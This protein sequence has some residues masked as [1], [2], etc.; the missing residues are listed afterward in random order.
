M[1]RMEL[2]YLE[3]V[4]FRHLHW[5]EITELISIHWA[6]SHF[7]EEQLLA[8][9][10]LREIKGLDSPARVF[11]K[12]SAVVREAIKA[13]VHVQLTGEQIGI[14]SALGG[15]QEFHDLRLRIRNALVRNEESKNVRP[16]I[17]CASTSGGSVN[18]VSHLE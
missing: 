13:A 11:R 15:L 6:H 2:L 18:V 14:E 5:D 3:D 9:A 8:D 12:D 1:A 10:V 4:P 17:W 7:K 16:W